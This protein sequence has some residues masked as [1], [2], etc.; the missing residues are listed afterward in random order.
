MPFENRR[1]SGAPH[2]SGT[3]M[4]TWAGGEVRH[5]QLARPETSPAGTAA[6]IRLCVIGIHTWQMVE[7]DHDEVRDICRREVTRE[8][9]RG[10]GGRSGGCWCSF[11][12]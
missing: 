1:Y 4:T 2:S 12:R 10:P 5:G 9:R 3:W 7:Y 8:A 6:C 11:Q